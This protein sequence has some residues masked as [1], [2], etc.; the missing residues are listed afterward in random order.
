MIQIRQANERGYTNHGWLESRHTFSF[1][2]YYAPAHMGFSH[3][4]V[5]NDD[6]VAPGA[7]FP[8]HGHRNM[9][10]ISYVL[11]GALEHKDNMGNGSIIRPGELQR[12][13]AGTGI[14]HSEYN[15]SDTESVRFL[16]IW[17]IPS[18][19]GISP[20]YEQ[21]QFADSE[22]HGK[23]RLVASADGRDGSVFIHQDTT[24]Y[25]SKLT[26]GEV[27]EHVIANGRKAWVQVATGNVT[28][29]GHSLSQGDGAAIS[30]ENSITLTTEQE[31]EV[32]VFDLP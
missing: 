12:M 22:V 26:K 32:L 6:K 10:I 31:A 27:V 5:I 4:R 23:L 18:K 2:N 29:N 13:S 7:G 30:Q 16:Q 25:A 28:V 15:A 21:Q 17:I 11:E 9:E 24:V 8:T 20:G 19:R 14:T 3:L 1:A